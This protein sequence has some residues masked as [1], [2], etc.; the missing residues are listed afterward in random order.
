MFWL[1]VERRQ[2][3]IRLLLLLQLC[4]PDDAL[5]SHTVAEVVANDTQLRILGQLVQM[6]LVSTVEHDKFKVTSL[7]LLVTDECVHMSVIDIEDR[8]ERLTCIIIHFVLDGSVASARSFE[9]H[10]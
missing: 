1:R 2:R 4:D 10:I 9:R 6:H 8:D 3:D 5:F 7:L